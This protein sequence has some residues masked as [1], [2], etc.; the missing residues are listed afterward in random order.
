VD[1]ITQAGLGAFI[2]ELTLGKR[3]GKSAMGWG[4]LFGI[5][6]DFD[7]FFSLFLDRAHQIALH[8]GPSH[9]LWWMAVL[10]FALS[11]PLK[12]LWERQKISRWVAGGFM[13]TIFC[14]HLLLES[15]TVIGSGMLWP[16]AGSP[17]AFNLIYPFDLILSVILVVTCFWL[18]SLKE[19]PLKKT[20]SKKP[21]LL[22]KRRKICRWSSGLLLAYIGLVGGIKS[23]SCRGIMA[24][25]TRRD[26]H[27]QRWME[28]PTLLNPFLRRA[29]VD[30]EDEIWVG[31]RTIFESSDS[32]IRWTIYPKNRS[33]LASVVNCREIKTLQQATGGWWIARKNAKGVWIGDLRSE[34]A[35]NWGDKKGMVDSRPACSWDFRPDAQGDRLHQ[36]DES[37]RNIPDTLDR[38]SYRIMGNTSEWEANPRLAGVSGSLPEFL[39]VTE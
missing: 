1:W 36:M 5:L 33:A 18:M 3:L 27:I 16:F 10:A 8:T 25:L 17:T 7:G 34:E 6:P 32:P 14:G 11:Y 24:D 2:G 29:V 4:A 37:W 31:Y 28:A 22:S 35:R 39:P 26:V 15:L 12:K 30:R 13:F 9:S 21:L 23:L 19:I 38:I 20:R